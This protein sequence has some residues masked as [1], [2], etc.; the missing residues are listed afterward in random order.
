MLQFSILIALSL[1]ISCGQSDR[2]KLELSLQ[3]VRH[4]LTDRRCEDALKITNGIYTSGNHSSNQDF[5]SL[6]AASLACSANFD[7]VRFFSTNIP[8]MAGISDSLLH[9]TLASFYNANNRPDSSEYQNLIRAINVLL[10]PGNMTTVS[11]AS[12][13]ALFGKTTND[14]LNA[15]LLYMLMTHL[16]RY[17][18]YYGNMD[19][20]AGQMVKGA[21]AQGNTCFIDYTTSLAQTGR[22]TLSSPTNPCTG[23]DQGH[24]AMESGASNRVNIMCEGITALNNF[25]E[26]LLNLS[27][28]KNDLED[29]QSI[30]LNLCDN[31]FPNNPVCLVKTQRDCE[32]LPLQD[33]ELFMLTFFE[34]LT[35]PI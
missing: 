16:G 32:N 28:L 31:A 24:P 9:S 20:N 25:F 34:L 2:E 6:H 13:E 19:L 26:I 8:L 18:R 3:H 14:N 23:D 17:V 11:N 15:Q 5:L 1:L 7:E 30:S 35:D 22:A 10:Y 21:G 12:R 4:L 33:L 27:S 29:L